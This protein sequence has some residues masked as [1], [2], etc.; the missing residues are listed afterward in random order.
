MTLSIQGL[1]QL[2]V[3]LIHLLLESHTVQNVLD[4]EWK[5]PFPFDFINKN[6]KNL[7]QVVLPLPPASYKLQ[8][9]LERS[10][11]VRNGNDL[12]GA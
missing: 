7:D 6:L 2:V 11:A 8:Q 12:P 4:D 3:V 1:S 5:N 10:L 9:V